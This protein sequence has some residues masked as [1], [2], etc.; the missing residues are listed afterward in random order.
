MSELET[1]GPDGKPL[2]EQP[3]WRQDFPIDTAQDNYISRRDFAKFLVLTSG[4]FAAGQAT[5]AAKSML[6][7]EHV[8]APIAV[9]KVESLPV[10]GSKAFVYPEGGRP[11]L[12]VRVDEET[13]VAFGQECTHLSCAVV[14]Q[15]EKG[16]FFCPCHEGSFDIA[17]GRPLAGPPRRPLTKVSLEVRDGVVYATGVEARTV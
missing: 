8:H 3:Q 4:A 16:R 6:S 12:L 13:F 10:G 15:P 14:P 1:V 2:V 17:T 11:A 5:I 9:A 7:R